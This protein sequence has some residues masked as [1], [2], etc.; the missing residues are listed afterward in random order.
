MPNLLAS[1]SDVLTNTLEIMLIVFLAYV[2][3]MWIAAV[4]WT[5]RDISARTSDRQTQLLATAMVAVFS[6]PGL[7]LY[8]AIRPPEQMVEIY[9]RQ[10]EAEALLREIEREQRCPSC[11]RGIESAFLACPYCRTRLQDACP[12]CARNLRSS[13]VVC[14]YCAAERQASR[15]AAVTRTAWGPAV[16]SV[17]ANGVRANPRGAPSAR[18]AS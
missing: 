15:P 7:M 5:Y 16:R 4:V 17:A 9:N 14:P 13:W 10:L 2:V 12:S 6:L 3:V 8:F 18:P 11:R 1:T